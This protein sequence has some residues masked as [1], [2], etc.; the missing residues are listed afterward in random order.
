MAN[1]L[2]T[3][4]SDYGETMYDAISDYLLSEGNNVIR[5]NINNDIVEMDKWGGYSKLTAQAVLARIQKFKPEIVLNFNGSCPPNLLSRLEGSKVCIVDADNPE[6][7]FNKDYIKRNWSSLYFLGLQS[8]SAQMYSSFL[9]KEIGEFKYIYF[10]PATVVKNIK[11]KIDKN[12]SFIG[13]NFYPLSIPE[14]I[15]FYGK[16]ALWLYERFKQDYY[17]P[18]SKAHER[19][20]TYPEDELSWLYTNVRAYYVGQERLKYMSAVS[21]LGFTFYGVRWWD[22]IAYYD[23]E[24]ASCFDPTPKVTLEENQ[25]VYNTSKLSINI[26]HPQA[27]SSFSW[28]VMDIMASGACLLMEDKIDWKELFG[29]YLD[30]KTIDSIIYKDRF[31]LRDKAKRLLE[32]ENLR[33]HCVQTLNYAIERNGRWKHR[34][35]N[36]ENLLGVPILQVSEEKGTYF[37]ID[38]TFFLKGKTKKTRFSSRKNYRN[39]IKMRIQLMGALQILFLSKIPLVGK[40]LFSRQFTSTLLTKVNRHW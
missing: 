16:D 20:N 27:K 35:G 9:S 38:R 40:F 11:E 29:D 2:I 23:F 12:I 14:G 7:F 19:L 13:S 39:M 34:F 3:Y 33:L 4:F 21:D 1:I 22:R 26:S 17:F 37:F 18:I 30:K 28:R 6:T 24:I 15:N 25:W 5:F 31:D 36:L 32:D 10:P 8:F